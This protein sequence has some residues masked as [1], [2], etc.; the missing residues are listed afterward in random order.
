MLNKCFLTGRLVRDPV[1]HE[2]DKGRLV[3]FS[4]AV[5][6]RKNKDGTQE[7]MFIDCAVMGK[8]AETCAQYVRKGSLITAVGR[9]YQNRYKDRNGLQH[10]QIAL[11]VD[12]WEGY[13]S[14]KAEGESVPEVKDD[15][16]PF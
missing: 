9:L 10:T 11:M 16:L 12:E 8:Q 2:T 4:L 14:Q 15:D 13:S 6:G 5:N 1:D 3:T 7:T